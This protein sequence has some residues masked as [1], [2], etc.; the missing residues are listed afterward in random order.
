M[1]R[2]WRNA[3]H[4]QMLGLQ[5]HREPC[6][7]TTAGKHSACLVM[8]GSEIA[9]TRR[10]F[11]KGIAGV[12]GLSQDAAGNLLSKCHCQGVQYTC[13]CAGRCAA[14]I[15]TRGACCITLQRVQCHCVDR[16][17]VC[18]QILMQFWFWFCKPCIININSRP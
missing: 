12:F 1:L 18:A 16:E 6:E 3:P 2:L 10:C 7:H 4:I 17:A 9:S 14:M 8:Q 15:V 5:C 13:T 11:V